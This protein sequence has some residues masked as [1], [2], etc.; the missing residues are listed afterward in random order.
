M[1]YDPYSMMAFIKAV[2]WSMV[3]I[4]ILLPIASVCLGKFLMSLVKTVPIQDTDAY[5]AYK[6]R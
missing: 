2:N 6:D 4:F 3:S 5:D 1:Q